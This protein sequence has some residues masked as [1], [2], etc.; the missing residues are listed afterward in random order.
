MG[1][2][3]WSDEKPEGPVKQPDKKPDEKPEWALDWDKDL[4]EGQMGIGGWS[5]EK[6]DDFELTK[7]PII[8]GPDSIPEWLKDPEEPMI[9]PV[10]EP[11][12]ELLPIHLAPDRITGSYI[13]DGYEGRKNDWHYVDIS[14]D[15]TTDEYT[16][17]N[18]AGVEWTL[19]PTDDY[20]TLRVGEDCPYF[21]KGHTEAAL[22]VDDDNYVT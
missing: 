3:G 1:I 11:E 22:T 13:I 2:G 18:R 8:G 15:S 9:D 19:Y 17:G 7:E 14:Y 12:E 16:W 5:D 4:E 21:K 6:P 20:L 10:P